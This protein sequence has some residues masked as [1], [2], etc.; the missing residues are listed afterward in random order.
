MAVEIYCNCFRI[1]G[2]P[3]Q[4]LKHPDQF[5]ALFIDCGRVKIIDLDKAV[6]AHRMRQR[7]IVL[8]ELTSP[9]VDHV[10]DPFYRSAAAVG[11]ELAVAKYGQS[12][13]QAKL[14]P[15]TTGDAV[16]SLV[17]KILMGDN[18]FDT[19]KITIG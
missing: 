6:R 8:S 5:S 1:G 11:G 13:L 12:F 14:E 18:C 15:V 2:V 7:A 19:L 3:D 9:Q 17:V 16:P 4:R 10:I